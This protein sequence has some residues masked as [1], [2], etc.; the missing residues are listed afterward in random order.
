M[1]DNVQTD[2][3]LKDLIAKMI[4]KDSFWGYLF[5]RIRRIPDIS[6]PSIMGVTIEKDCTVGLRYHPE[7][8]DES[9]DESIMLILEHEGMHLLNKHLQRLIKI[10]S[11]EVD[12]ERKYA[13]MQVWNIASDCA[14]N[15]Q[16]GMPDK[17]KI[18]GIEAEPCFPK[19]FNLKPGNT[20][21]YYYFEL[22]KNKMDE[23][24]MQQNKCGGV[25]KDMGENGEGCKNCKKQPVTPDYHGGW[26]K[27]PNGGD[28]SAVSRQVEEYVREIV[29][30]LI[31]N[32]S[33]KRGTL[34]GHIQ[35]I[36]DKFLKQGELPYYE[37]IRNLVVGSRLSKFKKSFTRINRKRTYLFSLNKSGTP[38]LSPFPGRKTDFTFNI[39]ILIDTSGSMSSEDILEALSS[40]KSIIE[41]DKNCFATVIEC[42]TVIGKEYKV[43]KLRDIQMNVSG[44]G[45]TTLLPGLERC[46]ELHPDITLAFSDGYCENLNSV[47]RGLMPKK[48]VWIISRGGNDETVN[49][50]G[51][52]VH[53]KD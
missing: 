1:S 36:L 6:I 38:E 15:E 5:S 34:P 24:M 44:R 49:K 30:D 43:R 16:M 4:L 31:K 9:D 33:R 27:C 32:F 45:G 2:C 20:S 17:L 13:K 46:R 21:E 19:K 37:I 35:E 14:V 51:F 10:I 53:L 3:K 25:C 7:L 52:V 40:I 22:L 8:I 18:A 11:T 41:K 23:K 47:S 48:L 39:C 28:P 29:K 26:C 42:D 50:T 12:E